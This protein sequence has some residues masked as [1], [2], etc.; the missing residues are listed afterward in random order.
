MKHTVNINLEKYFGG[1][2]ITLEKLK[3]VMPTTN[4]DGTTYKI[5]DWLKECARF[6]AL[7]PN[8]SKLWIPYDVWERG[9][10]TEVVWQRHNLKHYN[11]EDTKD[12]WVA[13]PYAKVLCEG[14]EGEYYVYEISFYKKWKRKTQMK[15][16][17]DQQ[18]KPKRKFLSKSD[19][20][21]LKKQE[22]ITNRLNK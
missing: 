10:V 8:V 15:H 3:E 19:I 16:L 5:E 4:V 11:T 18:K 12:W 21:E 17:I 1:T 13:E 2:G 22:V 9:V 6:D 7:V 14:H 20:I